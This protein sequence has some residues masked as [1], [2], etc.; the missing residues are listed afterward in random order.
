MMMLYLA[1]MILSV[2]YMMHC[3]A[4]NIYEFG[5]DTMYCAADDAMCDCFDAL[6]DYNM[7]HFAA[8]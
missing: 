5:A 7:I 2:A 4:D 6:F 8:D 1:D 3:M